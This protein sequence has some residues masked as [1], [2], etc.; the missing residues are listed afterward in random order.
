MY[1]VL[2]FIF[3]LFNLLLLSC[4]SNGVDKNSF[5]AADGILDLRNWD[6]HNNGIIELNGEWKFSWKPESF[7]ISPPF[8]PDSRNFTPIEVPG[9]WKE[10]SLGYGIYYLTILFNPEQF[11]SYGMDINGIGSVA[12]IYLDGKL[13]TSTG[14]VGIDSSKSKPE[15]Q[16]H[17]TYMNINKSEV[18]LVVKVSNFHHWEGGIWIPFRLGLSK[19]IQKT[20]EISVLYE[21]C[22]IGIIFFMSIY[23]FLNF[24]LLGKTKPIL[25]LGIFCSLLFIR[26]IFVGVEIIKI[27][28]PHFKLEYLI[29]ISYIDLYLIVSCFLL[30]I[31]SLFPRESFYYFNRLIYFISTTI[32]LLTLFLPTYKST[33]ILPLFL[34][35]TMFVIVFS[36]ITIIKAVLNRRNGSI[37]FF[38]GFVF[39]AIVATNDI[40]SSRHIIYSIVLLPVGML[41]FIF[42][43]TIMITKK[44]RELYLAKESEDLASKTKKDFLA[45][46][47]HE[48][49]TPMNSIIGFIDLVLDSDNIN[50]ISR[51]YLIN[52]SRSA[53]SLLTMINDILDVSKLDSKK[54]EIIKIPFNL[55]YEIEYIIQMVKPL[56]SGSL[57]S[58]SLNI[59]DD[60]P[61]CINLDILRLRQILV[62]LLGNAIKFTENGFV[63]LNLECVDEYI[64]EFKIIDSGIG[65]KDEDIDSIF[66][67]FTQVDGTTARKYGGSGLGLTICKDLSKLMGGKLFAESVY[68]KGSTFTLLLPLEPATCMEKCDNGCRTVEKTISEIFNEVKKHYRIL[69]AE[70]I[71]ENADLITI[72]LEMDGH[73]VKVVTNGADAVYEYDK[74][75]Y[76]LILMDIHMP[77]MDGLEACRII[78][79]K[80]TENII[81]IIALTASVMEEEIKLCRVAGIDQVVSKPI[82]FIELY[83]VMEKLIPEYVGK[84]IP[85]HINSSTTPGINFDKGLD[86]WQNKRSYINALVQFKN[87]YK[88]HLHDLK[89]LITEKLYNDAYIYCHAIKGVSGNLSLIDIYNISGTFCILLKDLERGGLNELCDEFETHM[90]ITLN[91]IISLENRNKESKPIVDIY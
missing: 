25:Y 66:Q 60:L 12:E 10:N 52:S 69:I 7:E 54:L 27:F 26:F 68:G 22:I 15:V 9:L 50:N 87:R 18:D 48:I 38:F 81:N 74:G 89:G 42:S 46:I 3:I 35:F 51:Q 5:I 80:E 55:K 83:S 78:R 79:S 62:N 90:E 57:I 23:L 67:S 1:K 11:G 47:S 21:G 28:L 64:I 53:K 4:N 34:Y 2:F 72:R 40:L 70:D 30:Y 75:D 14:T 86:L 39:I 85:Y 82:N 71:K 43:Q 17:V 19:H 59:S 16:H 56:I 24:F 41:L 32:I 31:T 13:F 73:K 91:S 88:G 36:I 33:A 77:I 8:K 6:F 37:S 84:D 49:R 63:T 45:N 44:S 65:I 76:D 20:R 61:K 58:L 29:K